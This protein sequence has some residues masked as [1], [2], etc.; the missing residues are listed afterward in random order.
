MDGTR[1]VAMVETL[2]IEDGDPVTTPVPISA[3]S[4][5]TTSTAPCSRST[6]LGWWCRTKSY[7]PYG[8]SAYRSR[9]V[10]RRGLGAS[11]SLHGEGA[12]RRDGALLPRRQVLR[13]VARRWT[14]ADPLGIGAD[15]P[16]LYNY[17]RGSP[18]V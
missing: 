15:G 8:A 17:T 2:T 7:L 10:R 18:I 11:L 16:G 6:R 5:A 12:G 1:R 4:S 9:E 14:S 3:S 13:R